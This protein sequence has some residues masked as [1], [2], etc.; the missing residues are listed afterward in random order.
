[1]KAAL[2]EATLTSRLLGAVLAFELSK[3]MVTSGMWM[4][5]TESMM[6]RIS[7][8]SSAPETFAYLWMLLALFVAPYLFLQVTGYGRCNARNIAR[9]ACW[10]ILCSGVFWAYLAYL[11]KNLDYGHITVV[12]LMHSATCVA[13]AAILAHGLNATHPINNCDGITA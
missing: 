4:L 11:S 7:R 12:L 6:G 5:Q 13:M 8:L 1:M 2:A 3:D 9:L 10:A